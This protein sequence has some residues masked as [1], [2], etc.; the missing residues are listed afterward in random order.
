[1]E[2]LIAKRNEIEK[3][4]SGVK[5]MMDDTNIDGLKIPLRVAIKS[6]EDTL[7]VIKYLIEK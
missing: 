5:K 4:I 2:E 1:M 3:Y 7:F 6:A